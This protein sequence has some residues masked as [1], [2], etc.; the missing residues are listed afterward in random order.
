MPVFPHKKQGAGTW[1][2]V[3]HANGRRTAPALGLV[4]RRL[5]PAW[6]KAEPRMRLLGDGDSERS[7]PPGRV[8]ASP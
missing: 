3:R 8:S 4:A 5:L 1:A 6:D 7:E 2:A